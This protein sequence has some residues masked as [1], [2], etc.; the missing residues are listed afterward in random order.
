[1]FSSHNAQSD[2]SLVESI[3]KSENFIKSTK[4]DTEENKMKL[5]EY[6]IMLDSFK[7]WYS[8]F[9][10]G[11]TV[12][13]TYIAD[14]LEAYEKGNFIVGYYGADRLYKAEEAKHVEKISL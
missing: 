1:M 6:K 11:A 13:F 14:L 12:E 10:K 2:L 3:K 5:L 8:K 9:Y 4:P 7:N